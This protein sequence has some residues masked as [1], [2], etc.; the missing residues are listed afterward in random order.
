MDA[1]GIN[2]GILVDGGV[3]ECDCCGEPPWCDHPLLDVTLTWT[4]S[5]TIKTW[6]DLTF[7]NGETKEVCPEAYSCNTGV[8]AYFY[9]NQET[10]SI[11]RA[12]GSPINL[13]TNKNGYFYTTGDT[14]L[15]RSQQLRLA[16]EKDVATYT[17]AEVHRL[18]RKIH[19]TDAG[20]T[21]FFTASSVIFQGNTTYKRR[22]GTPNVGTPPAP[23]P[24]PYSVTPGIPDSFEGSATTAGGLTITWAKNHTGVPW[25]DCF[26]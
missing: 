20:F 7:T 4:D 13:S 9:R 21:S 2:G 26:T 18:E 24:L 10:W 16:M 23:I 22:Y 25:G 6:L 14:T 1:I 12:F 11:I 15:I 17:N 8:S 19:H 5:S 3:A